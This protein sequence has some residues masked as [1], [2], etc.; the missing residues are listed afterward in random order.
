MRYLNQWLFLWFSFSVFV[1]VVG[2]M[3]VTGMAVHA[4]QTGI[5]ELAQPGGVP[6]WLIFLAGSVIIVAIL[7]SVGYA[8][9]VFMA[10]YW[11]RLNRAGKLSRTPKRIARFLLKAASAIVD[12]I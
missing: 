10:L 11:R 7:A 12:G 1:Y 6:A 4:L 2:A 8:A 3:F 5:A 9:V